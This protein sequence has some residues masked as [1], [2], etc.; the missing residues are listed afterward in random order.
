MPAV[1]VLLV[2]AG[3]VGPGLDAPGTGAPESTPT[4]SDATRAP[5]ATATPGPSTPTPTAVGERA[6]PWG[7]EPIVV[8]VEDAAGTGREWTPLVREATA[9]WTANAERFAGYPVE[10]DVRPDAADP[11]LVI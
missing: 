2:C 5:D 4:G 9:F 6:N 11:D 1:V 7:T 8:A 10:Y 3:C